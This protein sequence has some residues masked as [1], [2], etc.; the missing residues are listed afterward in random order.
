LGR[1]LLESHS[2]LRDDFA[3]STPELDVL[4][5]ELVRAGASGA[6]LTGAGFGGCV[7]AVC[8][9]ERADEVAAK[10]TARY[11]ERTGREPRAFRCQAVEGAG[12]MESP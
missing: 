8:T 1:L 2:S 7:V 12:S 9:Q 4:V 6:R 10:A 11:R 5:E 3:V